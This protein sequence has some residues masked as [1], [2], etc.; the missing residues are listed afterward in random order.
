MRMHLYDAELAGLSMG[1][2]GAVMSPATL[3]VT[4]DPRCPG[5][6]PGMVFSEFE[7]SCVFPTTLCPQDPD[8][9]AYSYNL[10]TDECEVFLGSGGIDLPPGFVAPG[11]VPVRCERWDGDQYRLASGDTYVGLAKA[12]LGDG[13]RWREIWDLNRALHPNP[14]VIG[15]GQVI[16]MPADAESTKASAC[17]ELPPVIKKALPYVA[18]GLVALVAGSLIFGRKRRS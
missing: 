9:T 5:L 4:E 13:E 18:A 1:Y 11:K 7:S 16:T 14:S 8:G 12:Y 2:A 3:G 17:G 15:A 10:D 6:P